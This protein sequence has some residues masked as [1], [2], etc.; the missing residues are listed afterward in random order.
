MKYTKSE[1]RWIGG[2][3]VFVLLIVALGLANY[4]YAT[5]P[6]KLEGCVLK[7]TPPENYNVGAYEIDIRE[8]NQTSTKRY[9]QQ[10][11]QIDCADILKAGDT[12]TL[13]LYVLDQDENRS[14]GLKG[15][16]VSI[17][18]GEVPNANDFCIKGEDKDGNP[19]SI[20]V[21][22]D[23]ITYVPEDLEFEWNPPTKNTDGTDLEDLAGH[24]F[25]YRRPD[26]A[27]VRDRSVDVGLKSTHTYRYNPQDGELFFTT[28][29]YDN[30]DPPNISEF[31][32]EV[33]YG[34]NF[35]VTVQNAEVYVMW[36]GRRTSGFVFDGGFEKM[37]NMEVGTTDQNRSFDVY[38]VTAEGPAYAFPGLGTG[39]QSNY[40][41]ATSDDECTLSGLADRFQTME[42]TVGAR[43]FTD[44][45]YETT[46]VASELLGLQ[47]IQT[48][49]QDKASN[50]NPYVSFNLTCPDGGPGGRI[51]RLCLVES[52]HRFCIESKVA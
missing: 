38:K 39:W 2:L 9:D 16:A 1:L 35:E 48:R 28:A 8:G 7:W 3:W 44:R 42:L 12:K 10:V 23:P 43:M 52:P 20:C 11:V 24:L 41:L 47:M 49:N 50:D 36:D 40:W 25:Y 46:T 6:V 27:Y 45:T 30:E 29:A 15:L 4:A 33:S 17:L 5:E 31:S 51:T 22:I 34:V 18:E 13:D 26:E 14:S 21:N 19:V 37:P 32:N